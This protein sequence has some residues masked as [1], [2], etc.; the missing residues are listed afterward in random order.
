[1]HRINDV[2]T[3]SSSQARSALLTAAILSSAGS[4]IGVSAIATGAVSGPETVLVVAGGIYGVATMAGLLAWRRLSVQKM[5][6]VSV[7]FY[8]AY[9]CAGILVA[10]LGSG[11]HENL[12][13][14]LAWFFTLLV[15]NK[16]V[17]VPSVGRFLSRF[18]LAAPL[19]VVCCLFQKLMV[20][21]AIQAVYVVAGVCVG[22]L[23][24]GLMLDAV[25]AYRETFI[26]ERERA[27][28]L[29]IQSEVLESISDC[30]ISLDS[31][32]RLVYLNDA[33]CTEFAVERQAALHCTILEVAP[34][35]FC[36]SMLA[37]L[38]AASDQSSATA[39]EAQNGK[40]VWYEIRCFPRR[41]RLSIYFRN[42]TESVLSRQQLEAAHDRLREQSELLDKAQD[43]IFVQD[44]ESRILYWNQGAE[45]VFGWRAE[46]VMGL[47]VGKVFQTSAIEVRHAF[48]SVVEQGEWTGELAKKHRDGRDLI[49]ASRCTLVRSS[50]GSPHS[51]LAIN[52][53]VTD[54]KAA[55]E[56]IYNLAFHDVLTGL[57]NR[58]LLRELLEKALVVS[59]RGENW[60]ALLLIDLDDFKTLNDTSGHDV[61]DRL[62]QE[63]AR[64]LSAC[65]HGRGT[66]ARLGGDEF[67]VLLEGLSR[68]G[69]NAIDEAKSIGD[70]IVR[71]C[72]RPYLLLHQGYEGTA[73][74]GVAI[75]RGAE[76]RAEE[77]LKRAD[78]ALYRAKAQ[79]RNNLCFFD[80]G[81]ESSAAYRVALLADLKSALHTG[82][83]ELHYQPQVDTTRR[84]VSCE[85]LLRWRHPQRGMVSPGEFIPLAE[86]DG[87]IV[88]LGYWVMDTACVQLAAWA[89][90]PGM[91]ELSMSVNVSIRQFL[92]SRFVQYVERSLRVSG[93]NPRKLKLEITESFMMERVDDV[94]HKMAELKKHGIGFSMDDFGTGYSSLSQLKRL[95]LDQLKIDQS[96]VR[97]VLIG[98]MDGSIV[99]TIIALGKSLNLAVIAEGV[100]TEEQRKFLE[101]HGCNAYQGYLFSRA[102]PAL[103]F[104]SFAAR[105]NREK[106]MTAA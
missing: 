82:E 30:F 34:G 105:I 46:E 16:L 95:P 62:L 80:P 40:N 68:N 23:C 33:A 4:G 35:F 101:L 44:M 71:A 9:L 56:R 76:A 102:L 78:L 6:A 97:D 18:I 83:F 36:E 51:I 31:Q 72:R 8:T 59:E 29:K 84:V 50:D 19:V 3:S 1:M 86:A 12:F 60:G 14:Y 24:F 13:V 90:R 28:S 45:R 94:I 98:V 22:Y 21:F 91:Q 41:G 87:L 67:V 27:E 55:D 20:L 85:A 5:A 66:A 26:V 70:A 61:G 96:F 88:D 52:T 69:E 58:A 74:V 93:A 79:G 65:I 57:P 47:P 25:T 7:T 81:M 2:D 49:V 39:F 32:F 38:R 106:E 17:N 77:L 104:E 54:Q 53:D 42:I 92:D 89:Q 11:N 37:G 73:S 75:F 43:A 10:V 99:R 15:F 63:V 103:E 100:E 48:L 64:R